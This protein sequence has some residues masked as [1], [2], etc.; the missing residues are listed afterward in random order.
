MIKMISR[1]EAVELLKKHITTPNLLKHV[2]AVEAIMRGLAKHLS[3]N[4]EL[5]GLVGLLHDL[6]YEK[7]KDTPEQ[8]AKITVELLKDTL[9]PEALHAIQAHNFEYTGMMPETK[10]D[11]ALI[12]ADALSGFIIAAALVMPNK[13]LAEVR[14]KTL[15]KK[16]RDKTFARGTGRD[17]IRRC[18]LIGLDLPTFF[19]IG[20]IALQGIADTLG[21]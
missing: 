13:K 1:D 5:W 4:E 11:N 18:E 7:T 20:L 17:R 21:L 15:K 6:D 14:I 16:F 10:L 9:P 19:E 8:H 2:Y 3:E 12:A